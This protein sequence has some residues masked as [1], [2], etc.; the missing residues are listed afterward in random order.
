MPKGW[1]LFIQCV[2]A[3][4]F[5]D[6]LLEF[7][8]IHF[9]SR[10]GFHHSESIL[11]KKTLPEHVLRCTNHPQMRVCCRVCMRLR[12]YLAAARVGEASNPGPWSSDSSRLK[13]CVINP[14]ALVRKT[15]VIVGTCADVILLSETSATD[16]VQKQMKRE[17]QDSGYKSFWSEPVGKKT[18][19]IDNRPSLRG[20]NAGTAVLTRLPCRIAR[21]EIPD[22]IKD[23]CRINMCVIALA[24]IEVLVV[25]IYGFPSNYVNA[26]R[27]T[28]SLLSHI[29]QVVTA[30]KIP[31]IIGG[32]FNVRPT[33]LPIFE[34][35][36]NLG[37]VEM[38]QVVQAKLG[39]TLP[40]TCR[41]VTSH[42]T[43]ILHPALAQRLTHAFVC[44][45]QEFDSHSPLCFEL[46]IRQKIL[47]PLQ[48]QIPK[49]WKDFER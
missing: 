15:K 48:W 36:Q 31:Y 33:D 29:Y 40:H 24:N 9:A 2:F 44:Q 4:L 45:K 19:T 42:D 21:V 14:T 41:G 39:F 38:F 32:D 6:T 34:A 11:S 3:L 49:S 47:Q 22:I 35:F 16:I 28:D 25:S 1:I 37:A 20:E 46:D 18:A 27:Y 12:S 7:Q 43:C 10:S 13:C 8:A 23:M 26:K 5:C 30:A 17:Y